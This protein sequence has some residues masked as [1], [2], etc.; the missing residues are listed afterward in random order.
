MPKPFTLVS[1]L[2]AQATSTGT[3]DVKSLDTSTH[4]SS[5]M[6]TVE[7]NAA[8]VTL[9][10]TTPSTSNGIVIP[11]DALPLLLPVGDGTTIKFVSTIAGNSIVDAIW[12][13]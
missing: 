2:T 10:G 8:R 3:A 4:A 13:R 12:L 1:N 6:I 5:V 9:D 7:T 11:K